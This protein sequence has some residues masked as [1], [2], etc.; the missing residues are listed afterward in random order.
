M[1]NVFDSLR[2]EGD[3]GDTISFKQLAK[4]IEKDYGIQIGQAMDKKINMEEMTYQEFKTFFL[5]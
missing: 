4:K 5:A 3:T 2:A 1:Q